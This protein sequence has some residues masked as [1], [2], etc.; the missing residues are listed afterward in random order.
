MALI[1]VH[2]TYG[3][4]TLSF[5]TLLSIEQ[6]ILDIFINDSLVSMYN[7]SFS[8]TITGHRGCFHFPIL[9]T[10]AMTILTHPLHLAISEEMH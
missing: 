7:G 3:H 8:P 1:S 5:I 2:I 4:H 10:V 9:D 6:L